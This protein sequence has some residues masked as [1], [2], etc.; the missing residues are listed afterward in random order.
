MTYNQKDFIV[1]KGIAVTNTAYFLDEYENPTNE[2]DWKLG[3]RQSITL[4]S[5]NTPISFVD[6]PGP[7]N[8]LLKV[9]QDSTGNR[10]IYWNDLIDWGDFGEP[11]LSFSP[12]KFDLITIYFDGSIYCA[13]AATGYGGTV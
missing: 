13:M 6:P 5:T 3:N 11:T 8:L 1:R 4:V 9:I 2:I 7:C 10:T 12:G